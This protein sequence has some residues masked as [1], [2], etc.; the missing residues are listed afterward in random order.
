M[1]GCSLRVWT[2]HLCTH[3]P[4]IELRLLDICFG[5]DITVN[6]RNSWGII[7]SHHQDN[8]L[9]V[10]LSFENLS[11]KHLKSQDSTIYKLKNYTNNLFI[12]VVQ[13]NTH[14]GLIYTFLRLIHI[15][16][17][18]RNSGKST[19]QDQVMYPHSF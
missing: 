15:Y 9:L 1:R 4:G 13:S 10:F 11:K 8:K 2:L 16:Q 5:H 7:L 12:L 3:G 6:L 19:T 14:L 18:T 17:K